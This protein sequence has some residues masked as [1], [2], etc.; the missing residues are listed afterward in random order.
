MSEQLKSLRQKAMDLP[1]LSGVYIMKDKKQEIIY[2]GKAKILKNRVS[3]Y[4][5]TQ[6][7]HSDKV[8]KMVENV[9]TFDYIITSTEFEALILE[10]SLIKEYSPKYNI[11]LKDGKGYNYIKISK[12][13]NPKIA[14]AMQKEDDNAIYLGPYNSGLYVK[15]AV[16]EA[17]KIFKLATCNRDFTRPQKNTRPC[18][19]FHIK[20]C[21]APCS[22][23][24][25]FNN[26]LKVFD[27]AVTFI[28]NG[29]SIS[30][31]ELTNQMNEAC[32]KLEFEQAAKLRDRINAMEKIRQKQSVVEHNVDTQDAIA[33][34]RDENDACFAVLRY[35]DNKVYDME[36]FI[37][38]DIGSDEE[39]RL[40]F[41]MQYYSIREDVPPVI[42]V[43]GNIE[44]IEDL[45][46]WL[47]EKSSKKVKIV[48]PQKGQQIQIIN[49]CKTNATQR[50]AQKKGKTDKMMPILDDLGKMLGLKKSPLYI[51]SYDISNIAGTDNV[52]G[53]IVFK[54]GYP[55]KKA[56]K[57][58]KIK[59][60]IGQDDYR[61]MSEVITRRLD[62]YEKL[63]D[64]KSDGF[65]ILP[66][67]I[68][69]DGG[70]GHVNAIE[71]IIKSRGYDIPVFGMVK[72]N[73]HKTKTIISASGQEIDII[74][75][76]SVFSFIYSIQ[77][78]VHRFAIKYHHEKRSK[79]VF[80]SSLTN[81]DGVGENRAKELLKHF[82]SIKNIQ[83]AT[84][85][86]LLKV[87]KMNKNVANAIY[88]HFHS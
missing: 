64:E 80:K 58:F 13:N 21:L 39:T 40:Q 7:N 77:E 48:I 38:G 24:I 72:D 85:E 69:L 31:K 11:L 88:Q 83:N 57:R 1:L 9:E 52:A 29:N 32:E 22:G 45:T 8:R 86:D 78:E 55:Y 59:S 46:K 74:F 41:I 20:Q 23:K 68:L 50:L 51:E 66:D 42:T 47:N 62:E 81:I 82:K 70:K 54:N 30:I 61:A 12:G 63:K 56:Y 18:L 79:N 14:R 4:F 35:K 19:N 53:M 49:L 71:P 6:N 17:N 25:S 73:K 67:L 60:F 15:N 76:R 34:V 43:D 36:H 2:I 65:A 37:V 16:E 75:N 26:Y 87:P 28:K 44:E 3:Q 27:E 84:V 10:C 5:G 33:F